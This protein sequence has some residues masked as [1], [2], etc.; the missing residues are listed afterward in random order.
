MK[1]TIKPMSK[2]LRIS[3][4]M[5]AVAGVVLVGAFMMGRAAREPADAAV[6][7]KGTAQLVRADSHRLTTAADGKVTFVEFVDFECES[8]KA[9]SAAID[10]LR[11]QYDGRV[12]FVVKYFPNPGHFNAE[13]AARAVEAAAQQGQFEPM[14]QKMFATQLEWGGKHDG[15]EQVPADDTFR[16]FA[17]DLKLDMAKYDK[18]Y[19][20]AATLKRVR[21]DLDDGKAF[22]VTGTP[23]FFLNGKMFDPTSYEHIVQSLDAALAS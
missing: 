12:T 13:R 21:Q 11:K 20:D 22:G 7:T 10:E 3:L 4:I 18:A 15:A 6:A 16:G 19:D 17:V 8:C 5:I 1:G 2:N 9:A 23:T 14:F